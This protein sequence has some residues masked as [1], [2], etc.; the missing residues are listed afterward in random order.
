MPLGVLVAAVLF[1]LGPFV[2]SF[3][4]FDIEDFP[5]PQIDTSIQPPGWA[6]S[7]WGVIYIWLLVAAV[8]GATVRKDDPAWRSHRLPLLI[9]LGIGA[10]WLPIS[11][12][13]PVA[14]TVLIWAMLL[15]AVLALVRTP[16][17]DR[18]LLRVPLAL[19]AGWLTAASAVSLGLVVPGYTSILPVPVWQVIAVV[20]ALAVATPVFFTLGR[21]PEYALPIFWGFGAIAIGA[22]AQN[23]LVAGLACVAILWVLVLMIRSPNTRAG[24]G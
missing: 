16:T 1:A 7:I 20:A 21:V 17:T 23:L 15:T 13:S 3:A 19:F 4:G 22:Y 14:A 6:F 12:S 2:T 24:T 10:T 5:N 8:A 9:A 18:W 11:E